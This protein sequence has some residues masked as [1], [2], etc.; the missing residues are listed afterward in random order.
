MEEFTWKKIHPKDRKMQ[1]YVDELLVQEGISRDKNLDET[2]GLFDWNDQLVATGSLF[3]N[4]LRCLAVDERYQ[5]EGL[6]NRLVTH[7]IHR[8]LE[9]GIDPIFLYTK[10][11]YLELFKSLGFYEIV[12]VENQLVFMETRKDGLKKFLGNLPRYP[13]A[14]KKAAIVMNANPFTKGHLYLVE[15]AKA[16][17][18]HLYI[19]L[20]EEDCSIFPYAVRK[21]LVEEGTKHLSHVSIHPTS[22]YLISS[23]TFPSYFQKDHVEIIQTQAKVDA[24]IFE[25]IA[26]YLHIDT[27]FVGSEPYS[28]V[29]NLY[30]RV[31][32]DTYANTNLKLVE[33]DRV[34]VGDNIISASKVRQYL[35][36]RDWAK[37]ED[38]VPKTTWEYLRSEES[39]E[40]FERLDYEENVIHY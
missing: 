40:I 36:E 2:Y 15:Q 7:L 3:D 17:C 5:G 1:Q 23:A 27:R 14:K 12:H 18:D 25:K 35:K 24:L 28:Q 31:L 4:T 32:K 21:R 11:M 37:V 29:T 13:E 10:S 20:V 39:A 8:Q 33:L 38:F 26:E 6:L 22:S 19:F 9:R 16:M 34:S 30:N